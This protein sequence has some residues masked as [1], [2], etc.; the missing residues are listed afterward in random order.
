MLDGA[1]EK[2]EMMLSVGTKPQRAVVLWCCGVVVV[3]EVC[4]EEEETLERWTSASAETSLGVIMM[5]RR[6]GAR[7]DCLLSAG[8]CSVAMCSHKPVFCPRL[9]LMTAAL[10]AAAAT[11][12]RNSPTVVSTTNR[13]YQPIDSY[14]RVFRSVKRLHCKLYRQVCTPKKINDATLASLDIICYLL[15]IIYIILP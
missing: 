10:C 1:E 12:Q 7:S 9:S 3:V 8:V 2:C 6:H 4:R 15:Y 5:S 14:K 13:H 11:A